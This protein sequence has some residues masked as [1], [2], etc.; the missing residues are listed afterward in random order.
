MK[1]KT[2]RNQNAVIDHINE[3]ITAMPRSS[4]RDY[5]KT[6]I[7]N[8]NRVY[9]LI[10]HTRIESTEHL[11]IYEDIIIDHQLY[12]L[13]LLRNEYNEKLV[14]W[15]E[16]GADQL[17]VSLTRNYVITQIRISEEGLHLMRIL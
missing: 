3:I 4:K 8:F 10:L 6:F 9:K 13:K 5:V 14:A 2:N 7:S 1:M 15:K 16:R 17:L 12:L 11:I